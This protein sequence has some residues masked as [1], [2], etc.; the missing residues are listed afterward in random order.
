VIDCM[1]SLGNIYGNV[2]LE[3]L[4]HSV[5]IEQLPEHELICGSEPA[6]EHEEGEAV[7]KR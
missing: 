3:E 7:A 4:I 2:Q 6:W 1:E 5:M